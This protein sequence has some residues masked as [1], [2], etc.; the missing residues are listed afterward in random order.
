M[1]YSDWFRRLTSQG[2]TGRKR[3]RRSLLFTGIAAA[4]VV[5]AGVGVLVAKPGQATLKTTSVA[6]S[7]QET[8][9]S[10]PAPKHTVTPAPALTI[11]S[12][13]PGSNQHS[14]TG[15]APITVGFSAP[16]AAD[17]PL[18]TLSPS[19]PGSWKVSGST[20][21][22]T[23]TQ[24][25]PED[26]SVTLTIPNGTTGM[27]SAQG[28][29]NKAGGYLAAKFVRSFTTA[30]YSTTRLE[31]L[32]AQ[33]QYLPL[34]WAPSGTAVSSSDTAGQI[35][36]AY[37]PPSG[38]FSWESGYPSELHSFWSEGS[39]NLILAGAIRAFEN[40]HGL[41]MDGEAGPAVWADV[42][43]DLAAG[44]N[45]SAG[46]TYALASK[47]EPESLTIW[48]DGKQV[49]STPAN[50][51]IPA[52]PTADGTF[53]VYEKLSFQIMKGTNPDGS[54]YSDPVKWISYFNGGD[55]VHYFDRGSY[56][57]AQSLGCVELPESTAE[58]AYNY[59]TYGSLVTVAG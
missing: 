45:N 41:T 54:K 53:P 14:V 26:T 34:T 59:L 21:T 57:F 15:T 46:Y 56:G 27:H 8:G 16:L 49:L 3:A 36:A 58:S 11:T 38:S 10:K 23:P 42:L 28:V 1:S 6:S 33:L 43:K 55:A 47:H 24:G 39:S 12:V 20:A 7:H 13:T 35:A 4:L 18:P 40:Q 44:H 37:E 17:S 30:T 48:H 31:Q 19:T 2:G 5:V 52:A 9:Q 50:T 25:Y 51:G 32:L 22:F 29:K